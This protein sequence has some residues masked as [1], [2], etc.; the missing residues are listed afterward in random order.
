[1]NYDTVSFICIS[2]NNL[3]VK[4]LWP[5]YTAKYFLLVE[6]ERKISVFFIGNSESRL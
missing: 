6:L 4:F 3:V 2:N 1:M 5:M